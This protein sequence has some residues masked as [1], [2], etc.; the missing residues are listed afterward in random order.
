MAQYFVTMYIES[1]AGEQV[2]VGPFYKQEEAL[3]FIK[4]MKRK[5]KDLD[6]HFIPDTLISP[7]YE[8]PLEKFLNLEDPDNKLIEDYNLKNLEV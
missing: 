4:K 8:D 2:H 6:I 7:A 5:H 3:L 1:Y